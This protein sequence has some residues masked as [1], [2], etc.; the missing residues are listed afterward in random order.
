M[1]PDEPGAMNGMGTL[2]MERGDLA[3]AEDWFA[4]VLAQDPDNPVARGGLEEVQ[5]RNKSP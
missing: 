3:A 2:A 1:Q 5:R 4:R